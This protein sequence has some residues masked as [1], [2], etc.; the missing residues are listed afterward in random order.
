MGMGTGMYNP[1]MMG[2]GM[3]NPMMMN[4]MMA[5]AYGPYMNPIGVS[6][7]AGA[8][9]QAK[10]NMHLGMAAL[11]HGMAGAAYSYPYSAF[12]PM[13]G[14][15]M[16]PMMGGMMN[17]MMGGMM[18]P[19]M[20]GMMGA[21]NPMMYNMMYGMSGMGGMGGMGSPFGSPFDQNQQQPAQQ[22]DNSGQQSQDQTQQPF[23]SEASNRLR[24]KLTNAEI[25]SIFYPG[26]MP[27]KMQRDL[28]LQE[29]L[30]NAEVAEQ[31]SSM[32]DIA[33]AEVQWLNK[34]DNEVST[35]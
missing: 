5:G 19:M 6:A 7:V 15:M 32:E 18:N 31:M 25:D 12:N 34:L 29:S 20:G 17:P 13:M 26:E 8:Q 16:N 1:M 3:Y 2:A 23:T 27:S 28:N 14:G 10:G 22:L 4:P 21:Y 30:E 33:P 9:H 35:P 24:R 11:H